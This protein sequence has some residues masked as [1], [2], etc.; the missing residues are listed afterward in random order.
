MFYCNI[1]EC[2]ETE[3]C[4]NFHKYMYLCLKESL[5]P[6]PKKKKK[7]RISLDLDFKKSNSI[8]NKK[9]RQAVLHPQTISIKNII[10]SN[11]KIQQFQSPLQIT[12]EVRGKTKLDN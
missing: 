4:A 12:E 9:R 8:Q 5:I 6:T 2:F 11:F 10:L 3:D 7:S 1:A